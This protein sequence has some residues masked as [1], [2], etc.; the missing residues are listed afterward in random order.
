[1]DLGRIRELLD[2]ILRK[3]FAG[4]AGKQKI[5]EAGNRLNI[6][7]PYCGDSSNPRKKRGNFY[8]DT[9]TYKCYNG[10][11]GIYKDA[12]SMFRDF[13]V[14]SKLDGDEKRDIIDLIKKGKEKRQTTYGDVDI[15]LFF[16]TDF[17]SV[18]IPRE[19][20]M[21]E[22]GLQEVKGSKMENYLIR[23]NQQSDDKFA[24]DPETGKLYLFNLSKDNEILGLQ[25]RNMDSTYGSKYYT[26]KLSG[27]WEKLLK[28]DDQNLIEEAKKIDPVSFVFN[29]GRISF[30]RTIT[31][32]E[33]PM[34]SWLW[35]NSVALC[36]IENKFPFDVENV[37]YW[38]DW[39]NAGRQKHS[40]LLSAG[41][42]VFNWKKFLVDHELPINKKWDLNDLVNFLRAKRIKI[43]RLDNYFTEEIL[44]L[45][46]FIYA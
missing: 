44:D 25:F 4:N 20:F 23:R 36:S 6:S 45:S 7:C 5:Y 27:I 12:F 37:Q 1:M 2:D 13:Q 46:D 3:E 31:I 15:S 33:G 18:V 11:C 40:E 14:V 28:T 24:W 9:L 41:K 21:Q 29:V 17:K 8:V 26:Y 32:F 16:D 34:D 19:R 35:K 43:R 39:D 30:D 42:R 22:M 38:Y 10:G